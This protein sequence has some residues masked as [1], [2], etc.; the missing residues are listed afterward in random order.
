[1]S[2]DGERIVFAGIGPKEQQLWVR[3]IDSLEAR[4]LAATNGAILP[5]WSPD[6]SSIG[7]FAGGKLKRVP[8]AGG[9]PQ[10]ICDNAVPF[11]AAWAPDGT[12]LY[13]P[14]ALGPLARVN[15]SG[16]ASKAVT[17]LDPTEEAHRWPVFLP[18]GDHFLFLGDAATTE[19][20]HVKIGSL[21]SGV[22]RDLAQA[23]SDVRYA[24][25]FVLFV[26][27]GSLLAQRLDAG[28]LALTG[29][30]RVIA[31]HMID[32]FDNHHHDISTSANGRLVYRAASS[33]GRLVWVDRHGVV[34]QEVLPPR[35]GGLFR[36]SPSQRFIAF[37]QLDADGRGDDIW[38]YDITRGVTSRLTAD[39][40][41][42]V[43]PEWSPD[44]KSIAFMSMRSG[45]GDLYIADVNNSAEARLALKSKN[46]VGPYSWSPDGAWLLLRHDNLTDFDI[47]LYS[48]RTGESKPYI[49]T[50]F[51]EGEATFS[52]DGK[53]VA[54]F[55][56]ASGRPEVYVESF[57]SH[58]GRKQVSINGGRL[59]QWRHDGKELFFV[60]LDGMMMALDM[61]SDSATPKELFPFM[62]APFQASPD[63]QRFLIPQLVDDVS[64]IPLT[65]VSGALNQ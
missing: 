33:E 45:I 13:T 47:D 37:E 49:A 22:T 55:S 56:D 19:N 65:F 57:P 44:G 28:K 1:L 51:L 3:P 23:V 42:D 2:P 39:P 59:P 34:Q 41:S 36:L 14:S 54:F 6:G 18:D 32:D 10:V 24:P 40:A 62:L 53:S 11:G 4:P 25:P 16:G 31:E 63:G 5:F 50:R 64:K 43:E 58:T 26:R 21:K 61:T 29:E 30:P 27:G 7:F 8:A 46:G 35:R 38:L 60:G 15:A 20:H 17:K 9:P 12:I 52:P 48:L